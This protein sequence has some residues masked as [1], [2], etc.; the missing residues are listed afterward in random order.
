MKKITCFV[1]AL[2]L[3]VAGTAFAAESV[4]SKMTTDLTKIEVVVENA[5][6]DAPATYVV[7]VNATTMTEEQMTEEY[8]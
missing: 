2:M 4:P 1:L 3:C 8:K 7:P 5:P 6:E